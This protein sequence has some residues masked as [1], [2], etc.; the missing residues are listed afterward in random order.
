MKKPASNEVQRGQAISFRIP[1]DTPDHILKHLQR[2]KDTERRNFSSKIAE[3]VMQ[4]VS[5]S[6]S[7]EKETI[8]I[9]L[10]RS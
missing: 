6:V 1:S 10:P 2:L 5:S 3:F 8:T 7:R 4:G 9:P